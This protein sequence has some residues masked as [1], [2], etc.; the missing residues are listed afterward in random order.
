MLT[1]NLNY[2]P[3]C[4]VIIFVVNYNITKSIPFIMFISIA[5][6]YC[7]IDLFNIILEHTFNQSIATY[8]V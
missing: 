8:V 6:D 5:M 1:H 2:V 4:V 3:A 7:N